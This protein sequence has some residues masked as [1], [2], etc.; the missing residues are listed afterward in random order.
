MSDANAQLAAIVFTDIV[1]YS[2]LMEENESRTIRLLKEHNGIVLP[3]IEQF[4]GEVVDAIGDGLFLLFPTLRNALLCSLAV[5]NEIATRNTQAPDDERFHLRIGIHLGEILREDG[6][7]FGNG[8]NIAARIQPFARPGGICVTEDVFRH[9]ANAVTCEFTSIGKKQL[10]N[11]S[12]EM[13]LYQ[14]RT[15]NETE[16]QTRTEGGEFDAIKQR[17]LQE[18]EALLRAHRER[19][20]DS[21]VSG[22]GESLGGRIENSV[23][24]LVERVMDTAVKSWDKLPEETK[25]AAQAEFRAKT[26]TRSHGTTGDSGSA[27][28]NRMIRVDPEPEPLL[29]DLAESG[30]SDLSFGLVAGIGFGIGYFM[31][32]HA[33]MVYPLVLLG[34][35]PATSGLFKMMKRLRTRMKHRKNRPLEIERALLELAGELGGTLTVVQAGSRLR[36]PLDDVQSRLDSMTAKGYVVQNLSADGIVEYHFPSL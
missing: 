18:R 29:K 23:F 20:G 3:L 24:S 13:T 2:R 31:F 8:V 12:R 4:G 11:I 14:V 6:K 7:A 22:L 15:G 19:S 21:D 27:P 25:R 32:G 1:G 33:W 16:T 26:G 34:A 35:L 36:L 28:A 10:R 9:A 17:I 5:Q 30:S